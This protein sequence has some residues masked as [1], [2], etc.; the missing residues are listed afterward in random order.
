MIELGKSYDIVNEAETKLS[1]E[2]FIEWVYFCFGYLGSDMTEQGI[3]TMREEVNF[4]AER[5]AKVKA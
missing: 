5:K 4:Q 1:S 3:K 2:R